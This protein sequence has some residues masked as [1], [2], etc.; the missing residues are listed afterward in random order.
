MSEYEP[1]DEVE[2]DGE[3]GQEPGLPRQLAAVGGLIPMKEGKGPSS[4]EQSGRENRETAKHNYDA[5]EDG[6]NKNEWNGFGVHVW[7]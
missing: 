4:D 5:R 7:S 1:I 6:H 3:A 2:G